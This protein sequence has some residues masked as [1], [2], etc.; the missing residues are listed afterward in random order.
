MTEKKIQ[1]KLFCTWIICD[2][3]RRKEAAEPVIYL[4]VGARLTQ[5]ILAIN[6]RHC[7]LQDHKRSVLWSKVAASINL[8]KRR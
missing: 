5:S 7:R 4:V 1:Q 6:Q 3:S 2:R 8:M